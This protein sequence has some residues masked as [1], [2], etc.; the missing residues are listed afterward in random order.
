MDRAKRR[1]ESEIGKQ[2]VDSRHRAADQSEL[3]EI[4]VICTSYLQHAGACETNGSR[5][6]EKGVWNVQLFIISR[7][8]FENVRV[9][10][11]SRGILPM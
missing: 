9:A 10:S 11:L 4:Y 2:V 1:I 7:R 3:R 8:L 5:D 6:L